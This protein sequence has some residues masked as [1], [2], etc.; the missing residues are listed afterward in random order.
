MLTEKTIHQK[1]CQRMCPKIKATT[2]PENRKKKE[3]ETFERKIS[4]PRN[5]VLRPGRSHIQVVF[6]PM[7]EEEGDIGLVSAVLWTS[8]AQC[9]HF[10]DK[11]EFVKDLSLRT[12]TC[13][14]FFSQF[15]AEIVQR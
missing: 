1:T 5:R 3:G 6:A 12:K 15:L 13:N 14:K 11:T 4:G 9:D 7:T 2:Q 8:L 10:L